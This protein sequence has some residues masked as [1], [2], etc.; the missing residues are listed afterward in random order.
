MDPCEKKE[1]Q[2][3]TGQLH[4]SAAELAAAVHH[5]PKED[6]DMAKVKDAQSVIDALTA[7]VQQ[8][9]T[10]EA[11]AVTL[12]NGIAGEIQTAVTAALAGGATAAQLAPIT[13]LTASL[14]TSAA[15][16]SQAITA[17]TPA[18]TP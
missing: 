1:I 16:L 8:T 6:S 4:K 14:Q 9:T 5:A 11:S 13:D 12:I 3:L 18:P 15:A 10:V 17:N 2:A 7:Q